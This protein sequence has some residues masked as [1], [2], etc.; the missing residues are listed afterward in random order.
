MD[1]EDLRDNLQEKFNQYCVDNG[2]EYGTDS[3]Y[4]IFEEMAFRR[5]EEIMTG[6][7]DMQEAYEYYL[8]EMDADLEFVI[9]AVED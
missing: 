8:E 7:L 6:G 3:E 4:D 1:E 2:I 9:K 5:I